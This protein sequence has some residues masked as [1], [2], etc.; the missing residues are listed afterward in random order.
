MVGVPWK[1]QGPWDIYGNTTEEHG[2][3]KPPWRIHVDTS[4]EYQ[5]FH[6]ISMEFHDTPYK[7]HGKIHGGFP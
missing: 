5:V 7:L 4:I 2:Q 3:H 1:H 6:G